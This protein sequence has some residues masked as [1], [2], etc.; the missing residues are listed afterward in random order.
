MIQVQNMNILLS[1]YT[2]VFLLGVEGGADL[3]RAG[4]YQLTE[5]Y[6]DWQLLQ[7]PCNS[8]C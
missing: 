1:G 2:S 5:A 8:S 6:A 7:I 4:E 3:A